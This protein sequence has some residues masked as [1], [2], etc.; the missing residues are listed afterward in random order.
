[1]EI[2]IYSVKVKFWNAN[3]V[4]LDYQNGACIFLFLL[5]QASLDVQTAMNNR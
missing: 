3:P 1:M 4:S 5:L 2:L